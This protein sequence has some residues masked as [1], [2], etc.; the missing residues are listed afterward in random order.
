LTCAFPLPLKIGGSCAPIEFNLNENAASRLKVSWLF[1]QAA[2]SGLSFRE[3]IANFR[4][5]AEAM[6]RTNSV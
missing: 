6:I 3:S 2:L 4:E 5:E 1:G